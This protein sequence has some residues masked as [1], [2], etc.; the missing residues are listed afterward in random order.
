MGVPLVLFGNPRGQRRLITFV[1]HWFTNAV[2]AETVPACAGIILVIDPALKPGR[3]RFQGG[4]VMDD[5][6]S[7]IL[8]DYAPD[9]RARDIRDRVA[10][11]SSLNL[12]EAGCAGFESTGRDETFRT[13]LGQGQR[14]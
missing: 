2:A 8:L 7:G 12:L 10:K 1:N 11:S 5:R 3:S 9:D 14:L 13:F 6:A 4:A